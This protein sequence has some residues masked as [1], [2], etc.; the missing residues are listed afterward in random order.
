MVGSS[1]LDSQLDLDTIYKSA[2]LLSA[3]LHYM[4]EDWALGRP[5][6]ASQAEDK[7]LQ[8]TFDR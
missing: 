3:H 5:C 7:K 8:N 2:M 4:A 6:L 1:Q